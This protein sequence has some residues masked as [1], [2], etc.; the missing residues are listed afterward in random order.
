MQPQAQSSSPLTRLP[1][2]SLR[3]QPIQV[4]SIR[5]VFLPSSPWWSPCHWL[6]QTPQCAWSGVL[7][8][9]PGTRVQAVPRPGKRSPGTSAP[10]SHGGLGQALH[11]GPRSGSSQVRVRGARGA[12]RR[13]GADNFPA[14]EARPR[15]RRR[16]PRQAG[17]RGPGARGLAM[18]LQVPTGPARRGAGAQD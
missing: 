6:L 10:A 8:A 13:E 4:Y 1:L 3:P 12:A 5:D 11:L 7:V 16:G 18:A 2:S 15:R 14:R 17:A 9:Q